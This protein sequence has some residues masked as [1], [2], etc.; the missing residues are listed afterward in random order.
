MKGEIRYVFRKQ[1]AHEELAHDFR[2]SKEYGRWGWYDDCTIDCDYQGDPMRAV[3]TG[4]HG[5]VNIHSTLAEVFAE[6]DEQV[7]E[8]DGVAEQ[9]TA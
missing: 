1:I 6:I 2:I 9:E 5:E 4:L 8:W 3:Y 7:E